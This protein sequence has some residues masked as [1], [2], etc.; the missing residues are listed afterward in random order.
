M[1]CIFHAWLVL[2]ADIKC[3][4]KSFRIPLARMEI[5]EDAYN[6]ALE[7]DSVRD[8]DMFIDAYGTHVS[9]GRQEVRGEAFVNIVGR[10]YH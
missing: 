9:N 6:A 7:V 4:M 2:G 5:S 10:L 8:A 3:P 1:D